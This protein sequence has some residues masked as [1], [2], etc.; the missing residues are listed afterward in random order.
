MWK[1]SLVPR[2]IVERRMKFRGASYHL[3]NST[4]SDP[5]GT[6]LAD[7]SK[8]AENETTSFIKFKISTRNEERQLYG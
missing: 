3:C 1:C 5:G 4:E 7:Q 6:Q 8:T 2:G